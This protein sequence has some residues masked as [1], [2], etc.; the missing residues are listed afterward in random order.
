M[1]SPALLVALLLVVLVVAGCL[2]PNEPSNQPLTDEDG[3]QVG[4]GVRLVKVADGLERPIF[5]TTPGD[6]R[7][8]VVEQAG[9]VRVVEGHR[10]DEG[11]FQVG[12][13]RE[14]VFL[15]VADRVTSGGEQG[16]L[17]L[18][19]HPDWPEDPRV[20][21]DYTDQAG[22][23]VLSVFRSDEG[24]GAVD[25]ASEQVLL[26]VEQPYSNHNGG[27]LAFGPD[28]MLYWALGDGG[29]GGDPHR[30]GQDRSTLLG[31]ILRL[32]VGG[33]EGYAIPD[34]NPFV[35]DDRARGEIWVYGLRNPW[36]FSFDEGDMWIGDV[37][38]NRFEEV[39]HLPEGEQAGANLGWN[40][41]EGRETF[42]ETVA[43]D[44]GEEPVM[45]VA[46]Y[47]LSGAHCAVTGG[48][49]YR[50]HLE[51]LSGTY[52][53]ADYCSGWVWGLQERRGGDGWTMG[54]LFES[55]RRVPSFGVDEQNDLYLV[56]YSGAILVF[57]EE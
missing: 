54:L 55:D 39:S 15:D 29:S 44:L 26:K 27:M 46:T 20:F 10:G 34:D 12:S 23:S 40:A 14:E 45:P 21:V 28:G 53:F 43:G 11:A 41:Y 48:Y 16:L 18:A 2:D 22:D 42:D 25:G 9:R 7:L 31:S 56:D 52:V 50:G 36:R 3:M 47:G 32:D 19:F 17:G 57:A 37:G 33:D 38:Q 30:H 1:R 6:G 4:K 8:Y 13:V 35:D 49:V 24:G 5:L 51:H